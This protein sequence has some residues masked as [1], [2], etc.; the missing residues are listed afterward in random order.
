M[1][2]PDRAAH[3]SVTKSVMKKACREHKSPVHNYEANNS[4]RPLLMILIDVD[5]SHV[6]AW[7]SWQSGPLVTLS[8]NSLLKT[9]CALFL[10]WC[11]TAPFSDRGHNLRPTESIFTL[12]PHLQLIK[13][14]KDLLWRFTTLQQCSI[15][16]YP[17]HVSNNL[18]H[19]NKPSP[20]WNSVYVLICSILTI[21]QN[22]GVLNSWPVS[23]LHFVSDYW[24]CC[25]FLN[26]AHQYCDLQSCSLGTKMKKRAADHDH[27][28]TKTLSCDLCFLIVYHR[29]NMP[30]ITWGPVC[31][32]IWCAATLKSRCTPNLLSHP[33]TIYW[34][35][36]SQS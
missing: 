24:C 22:W 4:K 29:S 19:G 8:Q 13:D 34:H 9:A 21:R 5:E 25:W 36:T 28:I 23:L 18:V 14:W 12:M 7:P 20:V 1:S 31:L 32:E 30:S 11:E 15:Q 26:G 35:Q 27:I 10:P 17:L 2:W 6:V 3:L 33:K 16:L